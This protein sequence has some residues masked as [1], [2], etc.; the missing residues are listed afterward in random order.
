MGKF[1][2][3]WIQKPTVLRVKPSNSGVITYYFVAFGDTGTGINDSFLRLSDQGFGA[4]SV[5]IGALII[6]I[7]NPR[8]A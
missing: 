4:N 8:I 2:Y 1:F 6:R 3:L 7:S 5:N